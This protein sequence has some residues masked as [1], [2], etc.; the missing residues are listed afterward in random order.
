MTVAV[1]VRGSVFSSQELLA[2]AAVDEALRIVLHGLT[3]RRLGK[4]LRRLANHPHGGLMIAYV[5]RDAHGAVWSVV[6][7]SEHL[8]TES[9][10][11]TIEARNGVYGNGTP[12]DKNR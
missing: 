5:D 12:I 1:A 2:H 4:K 6:Q 11:G 8:H 7:V 3:A 10:V 9:G